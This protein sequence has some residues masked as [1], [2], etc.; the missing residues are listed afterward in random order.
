VAPLSLKGERVGAV[1]EIRDITE[2][3]KAE[4]VM[5]AALE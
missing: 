5:V 4:E 2:D 1:L 3:V